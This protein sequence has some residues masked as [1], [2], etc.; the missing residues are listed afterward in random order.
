MWGDDHALPLSL[1]LLMTDGNVT[2]KKLQLTLA[3]LKPD[4]CMREK[5]REVRNNLTSNAYF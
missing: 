1:L 3:I 2:M 4:L 5:A